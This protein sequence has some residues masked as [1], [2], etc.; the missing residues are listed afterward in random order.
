MTSSEHTWCLLVVH[1]PQYNRFSYKG[2]HK[3]IKRKERS[4]KPVQRIIKL[5]IFKLQ[6]IIYYIKLWRWYSVGQNNYWDLNFNEDFVSLNQK[7]TIIKRM[8]RDAEK[9]ISLYITAYVWQIKCL[10]SSSL[11][12]GCVCVPERLCAACLLPAQPSVNTH[13][14]R[15]QSR[16]RCSSAKLPDHMIRHN[17]VY[18]FWGCGSVYIK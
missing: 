12:T 14:P 7:Q 3:P 5:F 18:S 10:L 17:I 13:W 11:L 1:R 4:S 6:F 8:G 16:A 15:F 2:N 9:K